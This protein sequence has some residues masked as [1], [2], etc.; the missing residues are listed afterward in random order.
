MTLRSIALAAAATAALAVPSVAQ[1]YLGQ[2]TTPVNLRTCASTSCPAVTV[3]PAG[4][5]V[6]ISGTAG[7]WYQASYG[8]VNGYI[9]SGYVA[10]AYAQPRLQT[11]PQVTL[12]FSFGNR[13]SAPVGG[14]YRNPSWDARHN[15]WYDGRRWYYNGGW[16][17]SPPSAGFSFGFNFGG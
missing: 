6:W 5:Q 11:Q 17:N 2:A 16:Y 8:G 14:F 15:A 10:T 13:P 12:G 3:V 9:A 4:G 1:A 7:S